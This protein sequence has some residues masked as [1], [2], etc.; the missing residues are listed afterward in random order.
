MGLATKG[1]FKLDLAA[2]S[3]RSAWRRLPVPVSRLTLAAGSDFSSNY[4]FSKKNLHLRFH[5][6]QPIGWKGVVRLLTVLMATMAACA[7]VSALPAPAEIFL[8]ETSDAFAAIADTA[9]YA[10]KIYS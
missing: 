8:T 9:E 4:W 6:S 1:C 5:L 2:G 7:L 3:E 10:R